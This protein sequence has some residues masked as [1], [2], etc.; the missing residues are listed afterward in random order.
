M[1]T[2]EGDRV[3]E[4]IRTRLGRR[5]AVTACQ[6]CQILGW[7]QSRESIV[8]RIIAEESMLW[9]GILI[10]CADGEGYFCATNCDEALACETWLREARDHAQITLDTFIAQC[11]RLGLGSDAGE[12]FTQGVRQGIREILSA[13]QTIIHQ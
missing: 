6:I 10:C 11:R 1:R 5:Q 8:R 13:G 2:A 7:P 9:S 3:C 4:L 12:A